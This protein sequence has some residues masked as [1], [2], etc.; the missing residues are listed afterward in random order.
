M[1]LK[2]DRVMEIKKIINLFR[3]TEGY[4]SLNAEYANEI[5]DILEKAEYHIE[6]LEKQLAENQ[7]EW[8]SVE[9]RLPEGG[10]VLCTDGEYCFV[11]K[12]S[13]LA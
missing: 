11:D 9:D 4:I 6:K 12:I 10:L 13:V 8:V 1:D 5:A 3:I 7:P 2:G